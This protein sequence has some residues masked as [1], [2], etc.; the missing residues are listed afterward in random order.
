MD[1]TLRFLHA[2]R[3]IDLERRQRDIRDRHYQDWKDGRLSDERIR[4]L[5]A[6]YVLA[7]KQELRSR[8]ILGYAPPRPMPG[9]VRRS[10]EG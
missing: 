7:H 9:W 6:G 1:E 3:I 5:A 10:L 2:N 8:M 4:I